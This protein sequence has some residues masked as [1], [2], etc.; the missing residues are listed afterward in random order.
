[1]TGSYLISKSAILLARRIAG[2][3]RDEWVR[4]MA[5][6][7]DA[8]EHGKAWWALGCLGAAIGDRLKREWRPA[9]LAVGVMP[10]IVAWSGLAMIQIAPVLREAGATPPVA[11]IVAYLLNPLPI[12]AL[13]GYLIPRRAR[14]LGFATGAMFVTAPFLASVLILDVPVRAWL[15]RAGPVWL[16]SYPIAVAIWTAVAGLGGRLRR[17][18]ALG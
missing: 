9:T 4:A 18:I 11:W 16:I 13:L 8:L 14:F 2:R 3:E 6:E 17:R 15:E 1:M 7:W 10:L 5:A 12:A